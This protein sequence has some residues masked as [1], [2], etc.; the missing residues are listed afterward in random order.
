[1]KVLK[2]G[3]V[4]LDEMRARTTAIA[5]R[6]SRPRQDNPKRSFTSAE[7][8]A[9]VIGIE[10]CIAARNY[11][12]ASAKVLLNLLSEPAVRFRTSRAL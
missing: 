11:A 12:D 8:I 9:K 1:M 7:S 4:S 3:I 5:R 6:E 10:P 2:I